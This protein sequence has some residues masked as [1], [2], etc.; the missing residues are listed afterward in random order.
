MADAQC[1]ERCGLT[2]VGVQ[3]PPPAPSFLPVGRQA[4]GSRFK[5]LHASLCWPAKRTML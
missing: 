5:Y 1:S 3:L 4:T 2:T